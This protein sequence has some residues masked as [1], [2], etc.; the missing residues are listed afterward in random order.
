VPKV[1]PWV[2]DLIEPAIVTSS[3]RYLPEDIR[4][5]LVEERM[6]LWVFEHDLKPGMAVVT[7]IIQYPRKKYCQ[8]VFVGARKE[9][10]RRRWEHVI[11]ELE[12]W[13]KEIGCDGMQSISRHGGRRTYGKFN[14]KCSFSFIEK[15]F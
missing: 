9:C 15:E 5:A 3:G 11:Y 12:K 6:Q 8:I 13:A 4:Q 14:Y 2:Q 7:E 1:W 10:P